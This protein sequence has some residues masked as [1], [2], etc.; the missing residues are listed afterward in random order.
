[1]LQ[2]RC[3]LI[4]LSLVMGKGGKVHPIHEPL[5]FKKVHLAVDVEGFEHPDAFRSAA[6]E[7]LH[8]GKIWSEGKPG[9]G[10]NFYL[11]LP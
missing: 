1:M 2:V 6:L 5:F 3:K 7:A 4:V 9:K 10:A 11:T 8:R